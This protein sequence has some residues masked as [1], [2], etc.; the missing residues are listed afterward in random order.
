[1]SEETQ[2]VLTAA[3]TGGMVRIAGEPFSPVSA[4]RHR[5]ITLSGYFSER[6]MNSCPRRV[7]CFCRLVGA[8]RSMMTYMGHEL[9]EF[10]RL[11]LSWRVNEAG[12][13]PF[14]RFSFGVT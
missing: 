11:G 5:L 8:G 6:V 4:M 10:D 7:G 9:I 13:V 14:S 3:D 12:G 1:M 2:G